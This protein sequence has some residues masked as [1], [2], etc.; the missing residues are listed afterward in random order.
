MNKDILRCY[1]AHYKDD[2]SSGVA[3]IACNIKEAK[4]I[5]WEYRDLIEVDWYSDMRVNWIRKP[6]IKGLKVGAVDEQI[7][8]DEAYRRKI[9]TN[10]AEVEDE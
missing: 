1:F 4:K 3:V 9:Y 7:S 6:D 8:L 10:F 2:W 5:A